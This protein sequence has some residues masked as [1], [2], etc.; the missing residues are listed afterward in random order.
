[1]FHR[2]SPLKIVLEF[3]H[4]AVRLSWKIQ[5]Q[6]CTS[7]WK[8]HMDPRVGLLPGSAQQTDWFIGM[9][10]HPTIPSYASYGDSPGKTHGKPTIYG[11]APRTY[12]S[13]VASNGASTGTANSTVSLHT[14]PCDWSFLMDESVER[15]KCIAKHCRLIRR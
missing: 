12:S 5:L 9:G 1:M 14:E 6:T 7:A 8:I 3:T 11:G 10:L 15:P 13:D 2:F 4:S